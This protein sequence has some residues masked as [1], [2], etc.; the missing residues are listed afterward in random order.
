MNTIQCVAIKKLWIKILQLY[1]MWIL[2]SFAHG[3]NVAKETIDHG[4]ENLKRKPSVT[5]QGKVLE[6]FGM[7]IYPEFRKNQILHL[8]MHFEIFEELPKEESRNFIST[9][10]LMNSLVSF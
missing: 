4:M 10:I 5:T 9:S 7:I 1:G 6:Y 3:Q 8:K 2:K